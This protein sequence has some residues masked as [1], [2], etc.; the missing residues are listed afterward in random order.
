MRVLFWDVGG[1]LLSNAWDHEERAQAVG[2]FGLDAR[3]FEPRHREAV[4]EFEQ[5]RI[6]L[7]EYLTRTVFC[8]KN[9]ISRGDFRGYMFSL[10]RARPEV[11]EFARL[12]AS[13]HRM[14]TINNESRELNEYRI[15]K[16]ALDDIFPL[17]VSSCYVGLRK[18]D[19]GIYRL[20]LDLTQTSPEESCFID[21]RPANIQGAQAAGMGTVLFE[22]L[23][24]LRKSLEKQGVTP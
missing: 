9:D 14:A 6:S 20:A 22:N 19:P 21:D 1:V 8:E 3:Q 4:A 23:D 11:L 12:L 16:F 18:P 24:Q 17:F 13:R 2:R 15:R 7:D 10:S 5:G